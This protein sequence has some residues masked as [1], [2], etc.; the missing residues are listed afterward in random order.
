MKRL[1]ELPSGGLRQD[2]QGLGMNREGF[3][4]RSLGFGVESGEGAEKAHAGGLALPVADRCLWGSPGRS[5]RAGCGRLPMA[6]LPD[7]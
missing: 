1:E 2:R 3:R 4:T 5:P 6:A 7:G